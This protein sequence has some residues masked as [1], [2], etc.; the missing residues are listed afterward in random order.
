MHVIVVTFLLVRTST[1]ILAGF[2]NSV[3]SYVHSVCLSIQL[4]LPLLKITNNHLKQHLIKVT[5][6]HLEYTFAAVFPLFMKYGTA[7]IRF[8]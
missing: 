7:F 4:L 3:E 2:D 5:M 6:T 1:A 8:I